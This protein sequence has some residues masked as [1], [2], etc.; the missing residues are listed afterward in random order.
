MQRETPETQIKK[1]IPA[2]KEVWPWTRKQM[3]PLR[4]VIGKKEK[5]KMMMDAVAH[6]A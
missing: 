1:D 3:S 6:W 4:A 5:N 2:P